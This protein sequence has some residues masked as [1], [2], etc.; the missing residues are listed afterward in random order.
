MKSLWLD[1]H[2]PFQ[3]M[4]S[5]RRFFMPYMLPDLGMMAA[6]A[7]FGFDWACP[8]WSTF[9]MLALVVS[10][11]FYAK[12]IL[13]TPWGLAAAMLCSWYF[14][15]NYLFILGFFS[16]Q[17]GVAAAFVVLGSLEA[18]RRGKN[19][20][21]LY[22]FACF[23]CYGS[24]EASFAIVGAIVGVVGL[25]R[26][27]RKEESWP[28][29]TGELLPFAALTV[30]HL[31]LVPAH[32]ESL[33]GK[34]THNTVADK[35]GHFLEAMFVRQNYVVE[36]SVL[37]LFW[38]IILAAMWFGFRRMGKHWELVATCGLAA[39]IYFVLPFGLGGIFYV[40]ERAL[41]FFFIPM[42]MLSLRLFEDAVPGSGQVTS[43]LVACAV[44]AAV[45]LGAL[46]LFLPRQNHEV[47]LY[48]E[49]LRSIPARKTVLP[50]HTRHRDGNTYP[51]RHAGSFYAVDRDGYVPYF[52][53][54][55]NASGPAGYF[56]DLSPIYRPPQSWYMGKGEPDWGRVARAYDFVVITKPWN[57]RRID[58]GRLELYF[59]NEVATVFR[60]RR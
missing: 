43:L 23:F 44:L 8:I 22:L 16:F 18:W 7:M 53:S 60:V 4:F 36:R 2:S 26:V 48:R 38:G 49:A 37:V 58:R 24:H 50:I 29:F 14:A 20:V 19:A 9:T 33:G 12:Q 3:G 13:T 6:I 28:R 40:D 15:T 55:E 47:A 21:G 39:L 51:L 52:F 34:L 46:A 45:N 17:W 5:A 54:Q 42:L 27:I 11:W 59:E 56:T 25:V 1:S 31:L 32:P 10:V 41:L 35:F 57:V 30:Y